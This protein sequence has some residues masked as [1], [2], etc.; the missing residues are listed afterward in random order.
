MT[1]HLVTI[2]EPSYRLLAM[3]PSGHGAGYAAIETPLFPIDWG[4]KSRIAGPP[5]KRLPVLIRILE[6]YRPDVLLVEDIDERICRRGR[7]TRRMVRQLH[8]AAEARG[9]AV[10][11]V[12]RRAVWEHFKFDRRPTKVDVAHAVAQRL[13][14]LQSR[15]PPVRKLWMSEAHVMPM[16]DAFSLILTAARIE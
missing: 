13:P 4:V 16:F 5:R 3:V 10:R 6:W 9:I 1:S 7:A 2:T 12:A 8:Q 15:L 11:P 14:E